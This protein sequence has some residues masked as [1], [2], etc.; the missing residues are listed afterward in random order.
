MAKHS[1][2]AVLLASAA[3]FIATSVGVAFADPL[4]SVVSPVPSPGPFTAVVPESAPVP[5]IGTGAELNMIKLQS[6]V[7]QRQQAVQLTTE[8]LEQ[9]NQTTKDVLK[10]CPTCFGP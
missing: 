4:D 9:M 8:M 1:A 7:S 2:I 5:N 10:N 6:L 3:M